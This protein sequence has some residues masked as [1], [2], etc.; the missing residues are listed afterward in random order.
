MRKMIHGLL[1][2]ANARSY[3]PYQVL[4][5]KQMLNDIME[6]PG[7]LLEHIRRYSNSLTTSM[8]FG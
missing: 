5:N 1:N 3:V 6:H 8:V 2:V 7:R 4:E